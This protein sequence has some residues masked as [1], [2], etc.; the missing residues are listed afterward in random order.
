MHDPIG[1]QDFLRTLGRSGALLGMA[2]LGVAALH[3]SRSPEECIN[4]GQ[5]RACKA[6]GACVLP[7]K[8][9]EAKQ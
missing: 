2:A 3:G 1:R 8:K 4:T 6:Y 5:C 9:E 7:E